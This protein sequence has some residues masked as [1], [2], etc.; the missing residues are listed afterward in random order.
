MALGV[1]MSMSIG[2][3]S[4]PVAFAQDAPE[5]AAPASATTTGTGGMPSQE[6]MLTGLAKAHDALIIRPLATVRVIIGAVFMI[7][8]S[9]FSA[10]SGMEGL[11]A[12]YDTLIDAPVEYAFRRPL[13]DFDY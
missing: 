5:A 1:C 10:P 2:I 4:A 8:A 12:S 9:V 3:L 13:G 7:P 6:E 11:Q